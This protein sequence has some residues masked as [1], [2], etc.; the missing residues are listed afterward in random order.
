[1]VSVSK[2]LWG[3]Q[4]RSSLRHCAASRIADGLGVDSA[5]NRKEYHKYFMWRKGVVLT[6]LPP[7]C[8]DCLEIWEPQPPGT[9]KACPGLHRNCCTFR[10]LQNKL[11]SHPHHYAF[12]FS[13]D[14][15]ESRRGRC[16]IGRTPTRRGAASCWHYRTERACDITR[17]L[18]RI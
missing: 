18:R 10:C 11:L 16:I 3:T 7:S 1:M 17:R 15:K 2:L 6:N 4:W 14:C 8:V 12:T 9:L 13:D 5:S